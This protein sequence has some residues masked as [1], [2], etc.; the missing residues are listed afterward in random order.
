MEEEETRNYT[1]A[2]SLCSDINW[3][4]TDEGKFYCKSC[5]NVIERIKEVDDALVFTAN[6]KSQSIS[7]GLK[8]R[9]TLDKGYEWYVCEGFQYILLMQA[10]ALQAIVKCPQLKDEVLCNFWRRY[11]QKSNQAFTKKPYYEMNRQTAIDSS[12][13]GSEWESELENLL[14]GGLPF[15]EHERMITS[16]SSLGHLSSGSKT[17]ATGSTKS[18][19]S[20][21]VDG[22]VYST[23]KQEGLLVMSMPMTL[24]FCYMSLVWLRESIT[25]SDLLRFV[26]EG[27]IPYLNCFQHFPEEMKL[28]GQDIKIFQVECLPSYTSIKKKMFQL[29]AFLD[30]PRFPPII[31]SCFLHPNLLCLKYLMEAN[32]PDELHNWTCRVVKKTGIGEEQFLTFDPV[33]KSAC[34]V[35]YEVQAAA[36]IVVVLKLLFLL[37]DK[38]EW[39]LSKCAAERNQENKDGVCWFD[40]RRWYKTMKLSLDEAQKK[41]EEEFARYT[42]KSEKTLFSS[43]RTK[44]HKHKSKQMRVSLQRQ[45]GRLAGSIQSTEKQNPFSFQFKWDEE[46]TERTCFHGHSLEGITQEEDNIFSLVNSKYWLSSLKLCQQPECKHWTVYEESHFP[47]SYNF[48]L[49]LFGFLLNIET[50]LIHEEVCLVERRLFKARFQKKQSKY[51]RRWFKNKK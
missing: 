9:K 46:N 50:S 29:A 37:N 47:R 31:E 2:C 26:E 19:H 7:R 34:L 4:L 27:H 33:A 5:H 38:Y 6:S 11:L 14:H 43:L 32:L 41:K 39:L 23:A 8:T 44:Q 1:E 17:S 16:D 36:V 49:Q 24:A 10:E 12:T 42:W 28:Y 35:H 15:S 40:F 48:L 22:G 25:L 51:R 20:G 18:Y 45:F 13:S 30:L 3:G 21:S